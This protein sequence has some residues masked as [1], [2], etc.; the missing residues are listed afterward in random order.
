MHTLD[1]QISCSDDNIVSDTLVSAEF[2]VALYRFVPE[3]SAESNE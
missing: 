2:E 1:L 3:L